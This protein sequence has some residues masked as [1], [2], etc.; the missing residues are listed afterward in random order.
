[1]KIALAQINPII[2]DLEYNLKKAASFIEKARKQDASLIVFPELAI[3]GY[4]PRD[5]IQKEALWNKQEE[6]IK[7]LAS[8]T[9][10]E[11]GRDPFAIIIGG[12]AKNRKH[13][14]PFHNSLYC[15]AEGVVGCVAHKSLLPTYDV[16]DETR[17]FQ[18][19]S[20]VEVWQ[21][22]GINF[23]LSVCEDIWTLAY[24][25]L[26]KFNPLESLVAQGAEI[27][28]NSSASPFALYKP[29]QREQI[30]SSQAHTY[31]TP[32]VYVNQVGAN[33]QLIFDGG[34]KLID[35]SGEVFDRAKRFEEDLIVV[36]HEEL[37]KERRETKPQFE[38]K[39]LFTNLVADD[40]KEI[41]QALILGIKDY[42]NKCKF[43]EIVIGLSGGI[44]SALVAYLAAKAIGPE[45]VHAYM[46]P[47]KF[48][49]E[50]SFDDARALAKNTGINYQE[51]SIEKLHEELKAL[52]PD[53]T[54][55]ADENVQ[56]RLRANILMAQAN[57]K[58]AI[59]L[60][61]GNKSE[62]AV[63]YSTLYG[64]SC[65]A[66][67]PIGDLLKSSIFKL[68]QYIN[69]NGEIIPAN[70]IAKPP[71]AELRPDQKDSD[72]LPEYDILDRIILLYIQEKESYRSIVERGFDEAIVKRV[73][74]MIDR[75]EYKRSQM[76]PILKIA[77]KA[78][79][80]G[81]RMPIAQGFKH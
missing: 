80:I 51:L 71:S 59:L 22:Q 13:G 81:R 2:G 47:S 43:K 62:I 67:A 17:Y 56:P 7:E 75:A 54:P 38:K 19:A 78:F 76:P 55:L 24:Q 14:K 16:F 45:N 64:D 1:M 65:G 70:I 61:T 20:K 68:C 9:K 33:D 63:G 34:S 12:I 50:T 72:S 3:I 11:D 57:T 69:R 66:I 53:L 73:L 60:A 26:Y 35:K 8:Y 32:I 79:G 25:N 58:N 49:S 18:E 31:N 39:A 52:I 41:E 46:L 40:Y 74:N 77:V 10:A 21:W 28:I 29:Q 36:E 5:L 30:I 27:I 6:I 23:G 4:P 42:I 15:L 44:D 48:T 37:L